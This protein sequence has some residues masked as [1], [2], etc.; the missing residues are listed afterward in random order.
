MH[1]NSGE[2]CIGPFGVSLFSFYNLLAVAAV[3]IVCYI[4]LS[5]IYHRFKNGLYHLT[6]ILLLFGLVISL[7]GILFIYILFQ[8]EA[9]DP[10]ASIYF[11]LNAAIK[12][13][14][15]QDPLRNHCPKSVSELI[16]I[17]PQDFTRLT[18]G[19]GLT[20][21]YYPETNQYTL[22]VRHDAIRGVIF[23]PRLEQNGEPDFKD[24]NIDSC[25]SPK[26]KVENPPYL[27]GLDF[28]NIN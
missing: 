3:L 10:I 28:N 1:P 19:R 21:Q 8:E 20:Y 2:L 16:A 5:F 23:D 17:Q 6:F 12:N 9:D 18:S 27:P 25:S 7:S 13:T 15:F 24:V 26:Y 4:I 22:V 14:C 11:P